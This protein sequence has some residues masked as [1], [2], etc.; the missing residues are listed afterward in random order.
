MARP[1]SNTPAGWALKASSRSGSIPQ[2]ER[3][4]K[5]LAQVENPLSAA[6]LPEGEEDWDS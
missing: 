5:G 4:V 1:C 6:V 2:P 3:T